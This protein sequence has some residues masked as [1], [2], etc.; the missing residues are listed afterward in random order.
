MKTTIKLTLAAL[1]AVSV[2]G[3]TGC[4]APASDVRDAAASQQAL[5]L[6]P[7]QKVAGIYEGKLP[8]A[9]C[10]AV[11]TTL[12]LRAD[13][14]YTRVSE[15]VGHDSFEEG[16]RWVMAEDGLLEMAPSSDGDS[17]WL[18]RVKEGGIMLLNADGNEVEEPLKMFYL[19]EKQ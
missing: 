16:G 12:Y 6:T 18:A 19:L 3:L 9:D 7:M 5:N 10:E 11:Q 15:Y 1:A 8:C 4:G 14:S 2:A 17:P 13:G